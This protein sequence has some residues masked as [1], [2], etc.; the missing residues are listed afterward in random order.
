M[1]TRSS[2]PKATISP[3]ATEVEPFPPPL[4]SRS[5][6]HVHPQPPLP[7]QPVLPLNTSTVW[8]LWDPSAERQ[9]EAAATTDGILASVHQ[10]LAKY[11]CDDLNR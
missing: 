4:S 10:R 6:P 1:G 7:K 5:W 8:S 2:R 9:K 11:T 3:P